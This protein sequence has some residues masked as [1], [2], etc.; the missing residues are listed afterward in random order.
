MVQFGACFPALLPCARTV[1]SAIFASCRNCAAD[2]LGPI[3][4]P[5][6]LGAGRSSDMMTACWFQRC[7]HVVAWRGAAPRGHGHATGPSWGPP[8]N[9]RAHVH[10]CTPD[11]SACTPDHSAGRVGVCTR[12]C[13][14]AQKFRGEQFCCFFFDFLILWLC[15]RRGT[16][17]AAPLLLVATCYVT[18][19][20]STRPCNC[21][22]VDAKRSTLGKCPFIIVKTASNTRESKARGTGGRQSSAFD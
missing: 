9:L 11:Q 1:V 19:Y 22:H 17:R 6:V 16:M 4:V 7:W 14:A 3:G 5:A 21:F 20:T 2:R 18:R 13:R 10:M 15:C 8:A 12:A